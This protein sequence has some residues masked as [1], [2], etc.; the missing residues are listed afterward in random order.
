[1][2]SVPAASLCGA[3]DTSD[4]TASSTSGDVTRPETIAVYGSRDV[5]VDADGV[6]ED[7]TSAYVKKSVLGINEFF[8]PYTDYKKPWGSI[9]IKIAPLS[10]TECNVTVYLGADKDVD[11]SS[12]EDTDILSTKMIKE[13]GEWRLAKLVY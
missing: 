5:Y 4:Q 2:P 8:K 7:G 3:S 13:N 12:V 1:M 6:L 9:S 11:L 10:E